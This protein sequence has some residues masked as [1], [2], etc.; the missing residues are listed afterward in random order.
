MT[1]T[2]PFAAFCRQHSILNFTEFHLKFPV[3]GVIDRVGSGAFSI[4]VRVV[5]PGPHLAGKEKGPGHAYSAD[6]IQLV[7]IKQN[8]CLACLRP[9]MIPKPKG[10]DTVNDILLLLY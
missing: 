10:A 7:G 8:L 5:Q 2:G 3:S 4:A 9:V 6:G 1:L